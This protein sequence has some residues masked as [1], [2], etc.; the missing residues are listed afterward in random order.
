ML[1]NKDKDTLLS[2]SES[3]K[4]EQESWLEIQGYLPA[5]LS[6]DLPFIEIAIKKLD[7]KIESIKNEK[8]KE[9]NH[10]MVL[11]PDYY[12]FMDSR[13][14]HTYLSHLDIKILK[15]E[16][17]NYCDFPE[18]I[19][20]QILALSDLQLDEVSEFLFND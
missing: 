20:I 15:Q 14:E 7:E 12:F 19:Q 3:L 4:M 18:D 2:F 13:G 1:I 10:R 9:N 6:N 17:C 11:V 8:S 5:G 16:F